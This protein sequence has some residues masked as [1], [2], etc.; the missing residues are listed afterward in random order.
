MANSDEKVSKFVQ[1][2]TE[3]AEEQRKAIHQEVE[4]YKAKRLHQA[5]Q[6]VLLDSYRL[7]QK[8][9]EELRNDLSREVSLRE[10][11]ARKGLLGRRNEIMADVFAKVTEK[12]TAYTATPEY[13]AQLR[14]SLTTMSGQMP[15]DGTIYYLSEQDAVYK[16]EL[17]ALC[18]AGSTV[19][20]T[21]DIRIGGI[22]GVDAV[23]GV[24]IDDTFDTKLG[25]Q[26]DWFTKHSGLTV[27]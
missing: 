7:I 2:I 16:D 24:M 12:I 14:K 17:A 13:V 15:A 6:E 1:A 9:R 10:Q 20:I 11:N 27:D 22:R 19:A 3:Y 5:E 21:A 4:E 25:L 23:G 8:E 26:R 18:P